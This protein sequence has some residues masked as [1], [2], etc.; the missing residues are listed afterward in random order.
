MDLGCAVGFFE[1]GGFTELQHA[2]IIGQSF[3]NLP[4]LTKKSLKFSGRM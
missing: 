1:P 4:R 2:V 3:Q